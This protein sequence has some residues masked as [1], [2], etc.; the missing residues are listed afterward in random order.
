MNPGPKMNTRQAPNVSKNQ[1]LQ[2]YEM[3][4]IASW[5]VTFF[6]YKF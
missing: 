4:K 5:P 1:C 2:V 6:F 3:V